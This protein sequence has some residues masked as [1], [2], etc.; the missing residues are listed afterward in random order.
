MSLSFAQTSQP[1]A[2]FSRNVEGT[3]FDPNLQDIERHLIASIEFLSGDNP[4]EVLEIGC[5]R[6]DRIARLSHATGA[7]CFGVDPSSEAI[8][9]GRMLFQDRVSLSEAPGHDTGFQENTFDVV[10]LGWFLLYLN[11]HELEEVVQEALRVL[12]GRGVLAILDYSYPFLE[13]KALEYSHQQGLLVY[14]R[15]Y[16][17]ILQERGYGLLAKFPLQNDG[18]V[19]RVSESLR[20]RLV[21]EVFQWIDKTEW[22]AI[23]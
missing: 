3:V 7:R 11:R 5:S 1:D 16:Q 12:R 19:T 15:N 23:R 6:G 4:L 20:D 9:S 22:E 8:K 2:W 13:D 17:A 10:L 14:R 18:R 21:L